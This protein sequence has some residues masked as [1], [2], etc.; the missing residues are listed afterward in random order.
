[1]YI[2]YAKFGV[3]TLFFSNVIEEKPLGGGES[4]RPPLVNGYF[5]LVKD[6]TCILRLW[7]YEIRY[8]QHLSPSL[9]HFTHIL[10]SFGSEKFVVHQ[11]SSIGLLSGK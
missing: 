9:R 5:L 3:S 8:C 6:N 7:T 4:V 1:M 10:A 2:N 11:I